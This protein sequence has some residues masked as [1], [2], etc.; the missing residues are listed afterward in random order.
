LDIVAAIRKHA[1][2]G[3]TVIDIGANTGMHA[4]PFAARVFPGGEVYAFEPTDY[5]YKRLQ[6]NIGLNPHLNV[7][8]IKMA[9]ADKNVES[10]MI[11]FR[12][13]WRTD[14]I[15]DQKE[16]VVSV[17]MLDD[18]MKEDGPLKV[19]IIKLDVDGYEYPILKGALKTLERFL[20][21]IF[22]EIGP[23]HFKDVTQNPIAMLSNMGYKFW[24]AKTKEKTS[25][26]LLC[27]YF[28][29]LKEEITINVIASADI[30]FVP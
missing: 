17:R 27:Q 30:N 25:S 14:G 24:N 1:R 20:P 21:L 26:A 19:D 28:S 11:N 15:V 7:K 4:L 29:S 6:E 18:W 8:G 13:T 16:N 10:Q 12:S 3:N 9:L 5:A 2:P 22:I 23:W